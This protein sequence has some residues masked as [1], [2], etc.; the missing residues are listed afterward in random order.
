MLWRPSGNASDTSSRDPGRGDD[1]SKDANAGINT[2]AIARWNKV[3]MG[4]F[5]DGQQQQQR[6][7][8]PFSGAS[9]FLREMRRG[10]TGNRNARLE[11]SPFR[12]QAIDRSRPGVSGIDSMLIPTTLPGSAGGVLSHSPILFPTTREGAAD[13]QQPALA[14]VPT[15]DLQSEGSRKVTRREKREKKARKDALRTALLTGR[16]NATVPST[17]VA[18]SEIGSAPTSPTTLSVPHLS[19]S[20][21]SPMHSAD[22]SAPATAESLPQNPLRSGSPSPS[23]ARPVAQLQAGPIA[24]ATAPTSQFPNLAPPAT[25]APPSSAVRAPLY[26]PLFGGIAPPPGFSDDPDDDRAEPLMI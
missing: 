9:P 22:V 21:A 25:E 13:A 23:K 6:P 20:S 24:A 14:R 18:R 7:T 12:G 5:R 26:S 11:S 4:T 17:P 2:S 19:F 3:P 10:V 16:Q 15:F 8:D 1:G